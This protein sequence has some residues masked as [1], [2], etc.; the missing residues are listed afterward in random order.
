MNINNRPVTSI[1]QVALQNN[2]PVKRL[3]KDTSD[4]SAILSKTLSESR[5]VKLSKHAEMRLEA[6]NI[7]LTGEQF[8][9]LKD[10]VDM[11]KSK[12]I[13]DTLVL[14]DNVAFVVNVNART[15]I[16]AVGQEDLK[17]NVFTNIDGAVIAR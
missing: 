4:F 13:K 5:D 6:R 9:R 1:H 10:A 15:V 2:A 8:E 7:S 14:M 12:G 17:E 11:A 16:T 3:A